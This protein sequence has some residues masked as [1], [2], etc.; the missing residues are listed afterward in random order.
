MKE[1]FEK[2]APNAHKA[3]ALWNGIAGETR[4]LLNTGLDQD[5]AAL[6][7]DGDVLFDELERAGAT[8]RVHDFASEIVERDP[9]RLM[10]ESTGESLPAFYSDPQIRHLAAAPGR[11]RAGQ[12]SRA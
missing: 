5:I 7:R 4:R 12:T 9:V 6:Y 2:D 8:S 10:M 3:G 1:G 11:D